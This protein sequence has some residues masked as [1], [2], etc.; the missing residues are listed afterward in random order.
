MKYFSTLV[1]FIIFSLTSKSQEHWECIVHTSTEWR[2]FPATSEPASGW[3]AEGFDDSS[4]QLGAGGIGYGDDDDATLI[5]AVNSLYLRKSFNVTDADIV[6]Q[7]ILDIDYDDAFIAYLNGTEVARSGNIDGAFP[8][9]NSSLNYGHEAAMFNGGQPERFFLQEPNLINGENLLA[10]HILNDGIGSSDLSSNIFLNGEI[11]S[12]TIVY[13]DVPDWFRV[14]VN[15]DSSNLPIIKINT[16]G[17]EI[18]DEPKITAQMEVINNANGVNNINDTATGYKGYIGIE[19]RGSSSQYFFDKYNYT[20]ETRT[21]LGENNNVPLLGMPEE[22]DWVFHGPYSDKT[23]MRNALAYHLA[24]G[25]GQWAPRTKFFELY[26]N[27]QYTGVY[28]LVEKIKRD[29]NRVNIAKLNPDEIL[30]DDLTGGYIL[31]IDRPDDHWISPYPNMHDNGEIPISYVYPDYADMPAAQRYYIKSYVTNF[32]DVLAA[33]YFED[34]SIGY[35]AWADLQS[36]VD[37]F[38]VN[39]ISKNIDGYR[40]STFMHKDK[41]SKGGKLKMGPVWDFNLGFGNADYYEGFE[42]YGWVMHSVDMNDGFAI[43]FWWERLRESN[44]FNTLLK[45]TWENLRE[46]SYSNSSI[47]NYIDSVAAILDESQE[48]NFQAHPVLGIYVWPNSFIGRSYQE[49]IGFLKSWINGRLSWMDSQIALIT[50]TSEHAVE[51]ANA[52]EIYAF[53]NPFAEQLTIRLK[54]KQ[55]A[56]I[57]LRIHNLLGQEVYL[58]KMYCSSGIND[59]NLTNELN[60]F[61]SGVYVYEILGEGITLGKGKIIKK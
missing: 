54:L 23:L 17:Q 25:S 10:I 21:S 29:K 34:A 5:S 37:F 60:N 58:S 42:T 53:P 2:Y 40:L 27:E 56:E 11:N 19:K 46:T 52:Y 28:L 51:I 57:G 48:R 12:S 8:A 20:V 15:F 41:D 3:H 6:L 47:N 32:E 1:F 16:S 44:H 45:T 9:Y 61:E 33:D 50:S 14:P 35:R 55:S 31:K 36:F 59:F 43:P 49:E 39:E 26:I 7:L 38:I 30:D 4:W 22:N 18:P 13:Q 24:Q